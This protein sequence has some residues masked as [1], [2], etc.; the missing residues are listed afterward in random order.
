MG[1]E[2]A[3]L[4]RDGVFRG[5]G[6]TDGR[7]QP[8][9]LIPGFMAGD[10]SLSVMG[11]WLKGTGHHPGRAGIRANVACSGASVGRLETRLEALVER[12]GRRAAIIGHSRGGTFAKALA[13]R[14]PDLVA[15]IV[16]L[17][18]PHVDPLE[19]VHPFVRANIEAVATLGRLHV[20]GMFSKGC[21]DDDCCSEFWVQAA[22][23]AA[24]RRGL[25]LRVLA[26]RRR[27]G[28]ALLPGPRG[29]RARG[30]PLQ[31]LRDGR[32]P[33]RLPGRGR[34]AAGLPPPRRPAQAARGRGHR[35][36]PR[37]SGSIHPLG[38]HPCMVS[39]PTLGSTASLG[40]R[41]A[42]GL[43][44]RWRRMNAPERA[45]L[46]GLADDVKERALE[47]RGH[48]RPRRRRP[49]PPAGRRAAG[50]RDGRVRARR[51]GGLRRRGR[52]APGR[53]GARAR[54]PGH[55]RG[56]RLAGP[57]TEQGQAVA[58]TS[59]SVSP[60]ISSPIT[61]DSQQSGASRGR[62]AGVPGG[63]EALPRPGLAGRRQALAGGPRRG[64]L[65][66]G[67]PLGLRQDH[68]HADGQPHDRHHRRRHPAGR[69]ERQAT[70]SRPSCGATSATR[71]SRSA[72]SP[73]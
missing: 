59:F 1:L 50:G 6:V 30:G 43:Y 38:H 18:S 71:S 40:F 63:H 22:R 54:A 3:S 20:P 37:S 35:A 73:T 47:L 49:R 60:E 23:P 58:F 69:R 21:L 15:G 64:D 36:P 44:G 34:R 42:R 41:V 70:A 48:A 33:R 14:R 13:V 10:N 56:F 61:T 7:G 2:L 16:T 53:P 4:V 57:G 26:Q 65:R 19:G 46:E 29:R 28:L 24:A 52:G 27:G 11:R 8:V 51:P 25:R 39:R 12:Q 66:A 9:L 31:P 45:R 5:Q 55:G 67:R 72:C 32:A 68:R 62:H 17:G